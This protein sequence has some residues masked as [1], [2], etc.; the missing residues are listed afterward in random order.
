MPA[1]D[2]SKLLHTLELDH[3]QYLAALK[4]SEDELIRYNSAVEKSIREQRGY[5]SSL[6]AG[7]GESLDNVYKKLSGQRTSTQDPLGWMDR[8][9][10]INVDKLNTIQKTIS[11]IKDDFLDV[12]T[13]GLHTARQSMD[14][15]L[16]K[17]IFGRDS[18]ILTAV[19]GF[20]VIDELLQL[21][22]DIVTNEKLGKKT[23]RLQGQQDLRRS[24]GD[25]TDTGIGDLEDQE[26][27]GKNF[28]KGRYDLE[29]A[30]Y[31]RK[32]DNDVTLTPDVRKQ[33]G[34]QFEQNQGQLKDLQHQEDARKFLHDIYQQ[35]MLLDETMSDVD[36]KTA[37]YADHLRESKEY[38][39]DQ[40]KT[41]SKKARTAFETVHE[42]KREHA[43]KQ[44]NQGYAA[45]VE[46]KHAQAV[47]EAAAS[48]RELQ[49]QTAMMGSQWTDIDRAVAQYKEHLEQAH[50]LSKEEIDETLKARRD[51]LDKQH[52]I[53]RDEAAKNLN[54]QYDSDN[55][56]KHA[57]ALKASALESK[58]LNDQIEALTNNWTS[59]DI[60]VNKYKRSLEEAHT[61]NKEEIDE[62]TKLHKEQIEKI[63]GG[64]LTR[65]N[66][67]PEEKFKREAEELAKL[68]VS[69]GDSFEETYQR[70]TRRQIR[71]FNSSEHYTGPEAAEG[72]GSLG[73]QGLAVSRFKQQRQ[74]ALDSRAAGIAQDALDKANADAN[75]GGTGGFPEQPQ[76]ELPPKETWDKILE[77]LSKIAE[78]TTK[79]WDEGDDGMLQ[80]IEFDTANISG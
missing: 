10:A 39:E 17:T 34:E 75:K 78:G 68:R 73:G 33:R 22:K 56:Q 54:Y 64:K 52:E 48:Q 20:H 74:L 47:K 35:T 44:L 62:A 77:Y 2:T 26:F 18:N 27:A 63:E 3:A 21:R 70:Q 45:D 24:L 13:T 65:S 51:E 69:L 28:G 57:E 80:K 79:E 60:E 37:M 12:E 6:A 23:D 67:K 1:F 25:V 43:A 38:T 16:E 40:I 4:K 5:W 32:L 7:I 15:Y 58:N 59:V 36:K 55:E 50:Q 9:K 41:E 76:N 42:A 49:L 72:A 66:E 31:Q 30:Q 19:Q 14:T 61:F 71:E 53:H 29:R 8:I 11:M 46:L